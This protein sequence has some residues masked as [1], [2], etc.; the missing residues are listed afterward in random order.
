[1]PFQPI[2]GLPPG[3][4]ITAAVDYDNVKVE[5]NRYELVNGVTL[6]LTA[7]PATIFSTDITDP[8]GMPVY[9][10][11]WNNILRITAPESLTG[12]P[13]PI[14]RPDQLSRTPSTLMKPLAAEEP[15]S[16]FALKDGHTLRSRVIVTEIRRVGNAFDPTGMPLHVVNS[17]TVLDVSETQRG[18]SE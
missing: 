18:T 8:K 3:K 9:I 16:E 7:L 14:P 12:T 11:T 13:T 15:W 10:I 6:C 1:L 5:W 17:Q 2:A 4:R